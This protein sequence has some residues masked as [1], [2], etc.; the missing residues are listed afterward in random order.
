[1]SLTL[2]YILVTLAAVIYASGAL[3]VKRASDLGATVW[4][5]AFVSNVVIAI[6]FQPLLVFGGTWHPEL[7]WQPLLV[8]LGFILGQVLTFVSLGRGDVSV[9]TPV[10]G[11]KLLLVAVFVSLLGGETLRPR[12][13]AAAAL[14][15]GGLALL[16]RRGATGPHRHVSQT[17]LTAALSACTFALFDVLVQKWSPVWGLGRFLPLSIG[18]AG[19]LS[20]AFIPLCGVSVSA[21]PRN[22]WP[23][24]LGG[25]AAIAGQ[26]VVFVSTI[27]RWGHAAPINVIYSSRGL[28]SILLVW[29]CGRWLNSRE[30]GLGG[31]VLAWRLAGAALMMSAILLVLV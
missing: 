27:A 25:S 3:L 9:A 7:W 13:W 8:A 17:I 18:L 11:I 15:T 12:L 30:A 1:M 21:L 14:A 29:S 5:T 22:A 10:L 19:V 28:W 16:N 2:P 4:T 26:S 23:W 6:A 24:L 20:F 31:H